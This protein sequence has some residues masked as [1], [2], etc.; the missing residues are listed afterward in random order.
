MHRRMGDVTLSLA[1]L[2]LKRLRSEGHAERKNTEMMKRLVKEGWF[3]D[4]RR[5]LE[6]WRARWTAWRAHRGPKPL[7]GER[8]VYP[9]LR[10]EAVEVAVDKYMSTMFPGYER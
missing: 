1:K 3:L 10:V 8:P 4:Y 6:A 5:R 2:N 9:A 7:K